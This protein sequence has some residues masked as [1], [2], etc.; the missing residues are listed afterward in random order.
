MIK[1]KKLS[2]KSFYV[3]G[4]WDY[5]HSGINDLRG[6]T[7][8]CSGFLENCVLQN[9]IVMSYKHYSIPS[10][11][12]WGNKTHKGQAITLGQES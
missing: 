12:R 1:V 3:K 9:Y 10:F 11:Y 7:C 5:I 8:K 6:K 2:Q 4:G